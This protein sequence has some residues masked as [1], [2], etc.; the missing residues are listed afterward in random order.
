MQGKRGSSL[1][2]GCRSPQA[3]EDKQGEMEGTAVVGAR[4]ARPDV[5]EGEEGVGEI[6]PE[7]S[8][9]SLSEAPS[10]SA[11][12]P[13]PR[14]LDLCRCDWEVWL[15]GQRW[16]LTRGPRWWTGA[17]AANPNRCWV[18]GGEMGGRE[19]CGRSGDAGER[20][21]R[22]G[23]KGIVWGRVSDGHQWHISGAPFSGVP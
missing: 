12:A 2:S 20:R 1:I 7:G 4:V 16:W 14:R 18:E 21:G 5:E 9:A 22:G 11:R 15:G 17:V 8:T 23:K 6:L 10:P 3:T 13:S 19:G